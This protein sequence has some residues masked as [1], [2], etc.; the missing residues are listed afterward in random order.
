MLLLD[1]SFASLDASLRVELRGVIHRLLRELE[2]T[3]AL[4]THDQDEAFVMG[5]E[6]AVMHDGEIR[7]VGR[8]ADLY[9]YPADPWV[10]GFVGD[11]NFVP[12]ELTGDTVVTALGDLEVGQRHGA[13]DRWHVLA[14][15]E[16]LLLAPALQTSE[17]AGRVEFV[18][19]YGHDTVYLVKLFD[20][21]DVKARVGA[22]P[23]HS[24]GD[25][26]QLSYV[27]P[28]P[29]V[30]A[31]TAADRTVPDAA[32]LGEAVLGGAVLGEAVADVTSRLVK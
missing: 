27:G 15:P 25:L 3:T 31:T 1:E 12:G 6:V 29:N 16:H 4:V 21:S 2:I 32:V 20:G 22:A 13:S 9:R 30:Y 17:R 28:P 10:A 26:V 5:D 14:R 11:A 18:E 24:E 19:F 8:P 23:V 7:Q